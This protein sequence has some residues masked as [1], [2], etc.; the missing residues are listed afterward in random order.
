MLR[1]SSGGGS[2]GTTTLGTNYSGDLIRLVL[3]NFSGSTTPLLPAGYIDTGSASD[4]T[5]AFSMRVVRKVSTGSESFP[6]F[7]GVTHLGYIVYS[8]I[9]AATQIT[10]VLGQAGSS[11]TASYSGVTTYP[12]PGV[13]WVG[14]DYVGKVLGGTPTAPTS[15]TSVVDN[16]SGGRIVMFDSNGPLSSYSFNT[17]PVSVTSPWITKTYVIM[18][19]SSGGSGSG[20]NGVS[21]S[22]LVF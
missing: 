13:D 4:S 18:G 5:N 22:F 8:G 20:S 14:L 15:A 12:D 6:T 17:K 1:S 7:S 3:V 9:D 16:N 11:T 2:V 21:M 19:G 10:N